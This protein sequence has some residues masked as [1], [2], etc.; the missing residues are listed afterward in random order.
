MKT[1]S[2]PPATI[3]TAGGVELARNVKIAADFRDRA[4]GLLG[5]TELDS[6]EGMLFEPGGSIH[7]LWMRMTIDV[8]FMDRELRV[9]KVSPAVRP[10]RMRFAPRG[11][12]FTLELANGK[13]AACNL[14]VGEQ[15][16]I[17]PAGRGVAA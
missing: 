16:K 15:L 5:R 7:T 13:L 10:W 8:A 12:H 2:S 3:V 1:K 6:D 9:L 4:V 14:R 17:V 11:T